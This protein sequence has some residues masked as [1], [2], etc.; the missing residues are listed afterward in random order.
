LCA[1]LVASAVAVTGCAAV[2]GSRVSGIS[3]AAVAAQR[4]DG[5]GGT[6]G[7]NA[8]LL[9]TALLAPADLGADFSALPASAGGAGGSGSGGVG[10]TGCPQLGVLADV[11][12]ALA[13]G[14]RGVAYRALGGMPVVGES[15]R[16]ASA[17]SPDAGYA[18]DRAALATCRSVQVTAGGAV[19]SLKLTP[20]A[21]GLKS[22]TAARLDGMLDGV[23]VDGYLAVDQ[24]GPAELGYVFLQVDSGA[25]QLATYYF[26]KAD[27]KARHYLDAVW[28]S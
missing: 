21:P 4:P 13:D 20:V 15:L 28:S 2:G 23:E 14:G 27:H 19:F 6:A 12:G 25:P 24:L 8:G 26:D 17:A 3:M 5:A 1:V 22:A 10:V 18:E 7:A 16:P 9:S 11:G